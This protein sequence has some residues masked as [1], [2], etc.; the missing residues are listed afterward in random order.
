MNMNPW[1]GRYNATTRTKMLLQ[2]TITNNLQNTNTAHPNPKRVTG[3]DPTPKKFLT[4]QLTSSRGTSI[5]HQV[6]SAASSTSLSRIDVQY[7]VFQEPAEEV[8]ELGR[9]GAQAP[10][11]KLQGQF[12]L[13]LLSE[14]TQ[15]R[16]Q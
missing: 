3:P 10:D 8:I 1:I 9:F 12:T 7:T 4:S 15:C 11:I 5:A 13:N 14:A 16:V 6:E 2:E